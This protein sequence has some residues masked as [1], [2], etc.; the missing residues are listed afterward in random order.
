[1][2]TDGHNRDQYSQIDDRI[3]DCHRMIEAQSDRLAAQVRAGVDPAATRAVLYCLKESLLALEASKAASSINLR[4][5]AIKSLAKLG[6]MSR[7]DN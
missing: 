3:A 5:S 4:A 1:M 6:T 2:T 7:A